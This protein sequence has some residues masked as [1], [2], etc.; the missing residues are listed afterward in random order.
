[1]APPLMP[2]NATSP[3]GF[4]RPLRRSLKRQRLGQ[5]AY[6]QGHRA[7]WWAAVYLMTKG[8]QILA[9]RHKTR[10]G[11]I[12]ILA[13]KGSAL[14]VVEVKRRL[15]HDDALLA[16]TPDQ[17]ARLLRAG[18][19]VQR[20]RPSLLGLDLRIDLLALAPMRWPRHLKG[21]MSVREAYDA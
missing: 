15:S 14:I 20:S 18:Q 9:F 2:R 12:D 11:E 1:M 13:R 21:L 8:Y 16:V 7:E 17:Y 4:K 19:S 3:S 6:R 5:K 10:G